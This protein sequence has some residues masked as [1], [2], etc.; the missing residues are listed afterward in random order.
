MQAVLNFGKHEKEKI[1]A[2]LE[3]FPNQETK[4]QAEEKRVIIGS[5]FVT[6]YNSGKLVVQGKDVEKTK[7]LLLKELSFEGKT[8]L[9][10][11]ES[12]RGELNG[13]LV[14]TGA[15]GE[16]N[17]LRELRDSK[18]TRDIFG[19]QEIIDKNAKAI[20]SFVFS[21]EFIDETRKK[22]ITLNELE[23]TAIDAIARA[24]RSID[25]NLQVIVDGKEMKEV[26]EKVDFVVKADDANAVVGAASVKAK[27]L[28]ETSRNKEKRKSWKNA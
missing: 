17:K 16:E 12:G 23:A 3:K 28:R 21:P 27:F 6:L 25:K 7:Q 26:K 13:V 1:K 22:G 15:L 18:K 10:I 20:S 9:G 14:V 8:I 19:K 2:F 11:D 24:F 4:N 5:D